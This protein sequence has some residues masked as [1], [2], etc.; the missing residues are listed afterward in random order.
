MAEN[1]PE[2]TGGAPSVSAAHRYLFFADPRQLTTERL[3]MWLCRNGGR[4]VRR[5]RG[6]EV[7]AVVD[8]DLLATLRREHPEVTAEPDV[9]LTGSAVG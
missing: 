6:G 7:L 8:E 1:H 5:L 4:V 3:E 9:L 2:S